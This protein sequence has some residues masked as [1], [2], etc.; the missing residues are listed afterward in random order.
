[1]EI[2]FVAA[3]KEETPSLNKFHHT[4]VGKINATMRLIELIYL[5]S[6]AYSL[7]SPSFLE[8]DEPNEL[9]EPVEVLD[10]KTDLEE[11][12][13]NDIYMLYIHNIFVI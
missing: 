3:L 9:L 6:F 1:M 13:K 4:G 5:P 11:L 12:E 8:L 2:L 7:I 10:E